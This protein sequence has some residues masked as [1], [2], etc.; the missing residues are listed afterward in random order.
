[1]LHFSFFSPGSL[2]PFGIRLSP[3]PLRSSHDRIVLRTGRSQ[4][5]RV[6]LW[7]TADVEY[8]R[9]KGGGILH[10]PQNRNNSL[11]IRQ[12]NRLDL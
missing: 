7:L 2:Y 4:R 10:T 6:E 11:D 1:M 9:V 12:V 8:V 3:V 5:H